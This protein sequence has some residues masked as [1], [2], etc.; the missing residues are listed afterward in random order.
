MT[1]FPIAQLVV[2]FLGSF[3]AAGT[4]FAEETPDRIDEK[5]LEQLQGEWMPLSSTYNGKEKPLGPS[6]KQTLVFQGRKMQLCLDGKVVGTL[7]IKHLVSKD[8]FGH[9]DYGS[10]EDKRLPERSKMLFKLEKDKITTCVGPYPSSVRPTE[11]GSP[12]GSKNLLTI[13]ER[14]P[15]STT[16]AAKVQ[17]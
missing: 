17:P 8:G 9:L 7:D 1:Q 4:A 14:K 12:E 16:S 2:I 10:S 11:L 13:S 3:L 6:G 15:K 5:V